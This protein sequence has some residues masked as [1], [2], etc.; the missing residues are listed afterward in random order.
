[1]DEWRGCGRTAKLARPGQLFDCRLGLCG[2]RA[3]L[4]AKAADSQLERAELGRFRLWSRGGQPRQRAEH[5][6]ELSLH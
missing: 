1:M 3:Q 6:R 5:I 2:D 4:A